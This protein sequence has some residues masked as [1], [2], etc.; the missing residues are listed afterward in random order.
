MNHGRLVDRLRRGTR[1]A[2]VSDDYRAA[3][4]GD[5][6]DRVMHLESSDRLHAK[7]GRSTARVR[8]DSSYGE[9]SVYLKRH[10]RLPWTARLAALLHPGG[11]HSPASAEWAHLQEARRLGIAV[12]D[13]VAAGERIGPWGALESYLLVAELLGSEALNEA[14][15]GLVASLAPDRFARL[16]RELIAEMAGIA[17]R[18]HRARVFHKDLYLCHFFLKT[19]PGA[20]RGRRLTLIDLHRLGE[21][22]LTA[23]RWRWKDLGQLLYSTIDVPGIEDRDRLRFWSHYR[24]RM[25][26]RFPRI[27]ARLIRS[28]AARYASHNA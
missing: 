22:R 25:G 26:L 19:G 14:L 20:A 16:K 12:P 3:L 7:Q 13:P 10:Y 2:W 24:R 1:W 27:E 5:L 18:L 11:R 28:K 15:P 4:P 9:L 6:D 23:P 17:A 8:F 21:H